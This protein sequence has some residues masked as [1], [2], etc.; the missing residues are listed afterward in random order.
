MATFI[1]P[2]Q[3]STGLIALMIAKKPISVFY[4]LLYSRFSLLATRILRRV[5]IYFIRPSVLLCVDLQ[6]YEAYNLWVCGVMDTDDNG[7]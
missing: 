6:G 4:Y 7:H 1:S 2:T 3:M 5:C